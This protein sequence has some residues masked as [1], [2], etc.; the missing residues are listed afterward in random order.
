MPR[1][2]PKTNGH[3]TKNGTPTETQDPIPALIDDAEAIRASLRESV[4]KTNAILVALRRHR[5]ETK[6]MRTTLRSLKQ[7]QNVDA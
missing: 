7:L 3:A 5:R 2:S 4:T 1:T 6:L